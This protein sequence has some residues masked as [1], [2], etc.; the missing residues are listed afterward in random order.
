VTHIRKSV[1]IALFYIWQLLP[2]IPDV[3][4]SA[5]FSYGFMAKKFGICLRTSLLNYLI[6]EII[7]RCLIGGVVFVRL[8]WST[9]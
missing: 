8:L 7:T 2:L 4:H 9:C 6:G 3:C 5:I 1:F